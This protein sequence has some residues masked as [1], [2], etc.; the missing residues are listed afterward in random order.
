M[1]NKNTILLL[2]LPVFRKMLPKHLLITKLKTPTTPIREIE[3]TLY[4]SASNKT[5]QLSLIVH[6]VSDK[7]DDKKNNKTRIVHRWV[8]TL[9]QGDFRQTNIPVEIRTR[10]T[11]C[12]HCLRTRV[13]LFFE[14]I[15]TRGL[16]NSTKVAW[17]TSRDANA[18][19]V[20]YRC[21]YLLFFLIFNLFFF[22]NRNLCRF[23]RSI[24]TFS[25]FF[26]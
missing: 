17:K 16:G 3:R 9:Q 8:A 15:R 4:S 14:T 18:L 2:F 23:K 22:Y 1:K 11:D 13:H 6:H 21:I 19:D 20:S 5:I 12:P 26:F 25:P 24:L 7:S 10:E